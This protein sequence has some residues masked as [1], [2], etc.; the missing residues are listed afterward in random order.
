MGAGACSALMADAADDPG[1]V[2]ATGCGRAVVIPD[3]GSVLV[4]GHS[5]F[6]A[7]VLRAAHAAS[8]PLPF[9]GAP[10]FGC[11]E[12]VDIVEVLEAC[13]DSDDEEFCR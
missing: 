1:P 7:F 2:D 13:D 10:P 11:D 9:A 12:A 3:M 5:P 4:A 8:L 6:G